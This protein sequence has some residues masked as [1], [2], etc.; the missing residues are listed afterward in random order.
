SMS[1]KL[2]YTPEDVQIW[3]RQRAF[4]YLMTLHWCLL[5]IPEHPT[6]ADIMKKT[7]NFLREQFG[8]N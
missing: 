6:T 3:N 4:A 2:D 7:R 5:H 8:T 1:R